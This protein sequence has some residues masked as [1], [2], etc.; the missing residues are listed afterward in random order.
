MNDFPEPLTPVD[1]DLRGLPYMPLETLRLLDSD[2]FALA[3]AEEFRCALVLW[4]K[5]WQQVPAGS[6]PDDD[7]ILA[8]LSGARDKWCD[9]HDMSL[10]GFVKCSDG[11]L[12]HPVVSEKAI[13]GG[14]PVEPPKRGGLGSRLAAQQL[15]LADATMD[16]RREGLACR[17]VVRDAVEI[18]AKESDFDRPSTLA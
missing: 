2:F 14:P 16:F 11:R 17:I 18:S 15:G 9:V 4:C 3:T 13:G 5:A 7:R 12:Y 8:H 1:C 10:H 6:L